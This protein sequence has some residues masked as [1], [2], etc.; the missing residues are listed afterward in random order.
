MNELLILTGV[1]IV[2]AVGAITIFAASVFG[3]GE[4]IEKEERWS[5]STFSCQ[6]HNT[7]LA[8]LLSPCVRERQRKGER[9][10]SRFLQARKRRVTMEI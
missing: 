1:G 2:A 9:E 8:P 7:I 10:Q 4:E 3:S 5:K 6:C